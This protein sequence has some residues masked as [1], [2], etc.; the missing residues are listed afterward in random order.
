LPSL[1]SAH[2]ATHPTA[3]H[4]TMDTAHI[5]TPPAI[6]RPPD[7]IDRVYCLHAFHAENADEL[8]FDAGGWVDVLEKDDEFGDGWWKGRRVGE[9][10]GEGGLFP[11]SYVLAE[12]VDPGPWR[13]M[14]GEFDSRQRLQ[15]K[16]EH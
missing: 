4:H 13:E 15:A 2:H 8:S 12:G 7:A 9:A 11:A 5:P 16:P 14:L 6:P 10:T 3:P 1:S